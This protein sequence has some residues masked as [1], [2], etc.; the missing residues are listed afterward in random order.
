MQATFVFI[1]LLNT[2]LDNKMKV[3]AAT[4]LGNILTSGDVPPR[5]FDPGRDPQ[6]FTSQNELRLSPDQPDSLKQAHNAAQPL[7][8][9]ASN[10]CSHSL[11]GRYRVHHQDIL[12]GT[13]P[14]S[15][16]TLAGNGVKEYIDSPRVR[17]PAVETGLPPLGGEGSLPSGGGSAYVQVD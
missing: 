12:Q 10:V 9:Q 14:P 17:Q 4:G 16:G 8:H 11:R 1:L 3:Y 7:A 15:E 13:R 6:H 5:P 2:R